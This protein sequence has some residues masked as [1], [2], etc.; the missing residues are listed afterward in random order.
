MHSHPYLTLSPR[1]EYCTFGEKFSIYKDFFLRLFIHKRHREREAETQAEGE[2]G[3]TQGAGCGT[4]S[5][6]SRI[7]PWAEGGAKPLSHPGCPI[8]FNCEIC[9][10][11]YVDIQ[12]RTFKTMYQPIENIPRTF[13]PLIE[14][15]YWGRECNWMSQK[16]N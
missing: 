5:W 6:V 3:S 4:P 7:K 11:E 13:N 15:S 12:F 16:D 2:A 10:F 1:A 14:L 9:L 8:I